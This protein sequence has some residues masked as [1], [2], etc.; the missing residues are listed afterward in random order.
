MSRVTDSK[1]RTMTNI[2]QE[3]VAR[4][5]F[6]ELSIIISSELNDPRLSLVSVT[7]VVISRD[8]RNA[9][10]YVS[11]DDEEVGKNEVLRGLQRAVPYM[12]GE[13][14]SRCGLRMVPELL[15]H[16]DETPERA[17]R[18]DA[19]LAQIAEEREKTSQDEI[20]QDSD[21]PDTDIPKYPSCSR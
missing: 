1:S 20:W 4:L 9:K 2:R 5:L 7:D 21:T 13:V 8:L 3:R 6:E 14:A 12:R 17:V 15:F 18:V 11:H 16:Y 19:L 10:V